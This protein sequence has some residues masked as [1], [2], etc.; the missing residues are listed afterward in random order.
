[1]GLVE[2]ILYGVLIAAFFLFNQLMQWLARRAKARQV[3]VPTGTEAWGRAGPQPVE[4]PVDIGSGPWRRAG[5]RR[6]SVPGPT[7]ATRSWR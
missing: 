3:Q 6:R 5:V 4:I 7:C 2:L 1:M